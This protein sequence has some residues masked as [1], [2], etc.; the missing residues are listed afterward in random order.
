MHR[1]KYSYLGEERSFA[2]CWSQI[3]FHTDHWWRNILRWPRQVRSGEFNFPPL[4]LAPSM[5]VG[6]AW[7][8]CNGS[9]N[10]K[11]KQV[12]GGSLY[13]WMWK[14]VWTHI[15]SPWTKSQRTWSLGPLQVTDQT[16]LY[17]G[18]LWKQSA[19]HSWTWNR[20]EPRLFSSAV[21]QQVS[22]R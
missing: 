13:Y 3:Q 5:R 16:C 19:C 21:C 8:L 20:N 2:F 6:L 10:T 17:P 4:V 18:R 1:Y 22:T 7:T 9:L 14:A 11:R 12:G 15:G